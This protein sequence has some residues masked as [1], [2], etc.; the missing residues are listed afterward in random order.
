MQNI[1]HIHAHFH[2]HVCPGKKYNPNHQC[3]NKNCHLNGRPGHCEKCVKQVDTHINK[4][5]NP[6][7]RYHNK[8]GFKTCTSDR[9]F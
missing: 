4:N 6:I 9:C 7:I 3:P 8:I 1:F 5:A 2:F